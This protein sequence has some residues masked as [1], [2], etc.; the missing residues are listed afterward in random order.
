[1]PTRRQ[2]AEAMQAAAAMDQGTSAKR[3][4]AESGR[5]QQ[6]NHA[7]ESRER[8]RRTKSAA[9]A[10]GSAPSAAASAASAPA[11]P[12]QEDEAATPTLGGAKTD[13]YED[14]V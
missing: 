3:A 8:R 4:T 2:L 7:V 1:M 10:S 12:G 11:A 9:E 5:D 13:E 14:D 6:G